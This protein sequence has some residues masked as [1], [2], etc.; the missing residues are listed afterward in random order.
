[1]SKSEFIREQAT[2]ELV[3]MSNRYV[4]EDAEL[5]TALLILAASISK[6]EVG[7]AILGMGLVLTHE[8]KGEQ[9]AHD[10][11]DQNAG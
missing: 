3:D 7:K 2:Q 6:G 5:S 11:R 9:N 8:P 10:N 4:S 1:M